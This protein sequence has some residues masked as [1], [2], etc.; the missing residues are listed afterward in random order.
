MKEVFS[1]TDIFYNHL[2]GIKSS[3]L[4][5]L[6]PSKKIYPYASAMSNS[7]PDWILNHLDEL[8]ET[9]AFDTTSFKIG[10]KYYTPT[11]IE[12]DEFIPD[13]D[14]Y[15]N[16]VLHNYINECIIFIKKFIKNYAYIKTANIE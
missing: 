14:I 15:E 16:R 1:S 6:V 3:K 12:V 9:S 2:G 5:K 7:N 10:R 4:Y 13:T 11:H 8:V